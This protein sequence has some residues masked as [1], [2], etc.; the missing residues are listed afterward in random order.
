M[1]RATLPQGAPRRLIAAFVLLL[2]LPA[3]AVVWLGVRLVIQDQQL[4]TERLRT[5]REAAAEQL[6]NELN[7]RLSAAEG[8]L[9]SEAP[10]GDDAVRLVIG[11]D[12][13]QTRP[14][15]RLLYYP[16]LQVGSSEMLPAFAPGEE[17][18]YQRQDFDAA[19]AEYRRLTGDR[20]PSVRAGALVRLARVLRKAGRPEQALEIYGSLAR[21]RGVAVD[22]L[23]AD[24]VA[25]RARCRVLE[26]I[27]QTARLRDEAAA[28]QSDLT[29]GTWE[30][31]HGTFTQYEGEVAAW[32]GSAVAVPPAQRALA[33]AAAWLWERRE[34]EG[35][36]A[37]RF[38]DVELS[39]LWQS[40]DGRTRALV[41]GPEFQ[42][43]Q[44]FSAIQIGS[45][46]HDTQVALATAAGPVFGGA[47]DVRDLETL[48]RPSSQTGLPWAI[49]VRTRRDASI[50]SSRR[51]AI[52]LGLGFLTLLVVAGGYVIGRAVSRELAVARLQSDFVA[53]VSHEFRTPLTSLRQFTDLLREADDLTPD[54]RRGFYAAQARATDRLQRLVESL[55]DFRRMEAG[56]HPYQ[57]QR[58]PA[59]PLVEAVVDDF[60]R[61][62]APG[63]DVEYAHTGDERTIDAD[64]DALSL[65]LWNL[66]DNAVKYSGDDRRVSVSLAGRNGSVEINV[67][68]RGHGV[69]PDEQQEIFRPFVRGRDARARGIRGP[70]LGLA[71]VQHIVRGHG[72]RVA[73]ESTPGHGST[74]TI[75]L[76]AAD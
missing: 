32:L 73:L 43:R 66:L 70:G 68:D 61:E 19:E 22:G 65:A 56:T 28:L 44:W 6:V 58:I 37:G 35:R 64:P 33:E 55:L 16:G 1:F 52:L 53:S 21:L 20:S 15:T 63:F 50:G 36:H 49:T 18:E 17:L 46:A 60:R 9:V 29:A 38:G 57:R 72:G 26:E 67:R 12:G 34:T 69:P 71:M 74:F 8:N 75:V 25:R 48:I 13:V 59:S 41:A 10:P 31:D 4:E 7:T 24:L 42:R 51:L 62:A 23:P 5:Q 14:A 54:K 47:P 30:I 11:A 39:L 45:A 3:V 40:S 76:P 2:L 27:K